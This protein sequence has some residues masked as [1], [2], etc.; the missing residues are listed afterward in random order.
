MDAKLIPA[1]YASKYDNGTEIKRW[2]D[3][4]CTADLESRRVGTPRLRQLR[5]KP[6]KFTQV[7][8]KRIIQ[9]LLYVRKV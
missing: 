7:Q 4:R 6:G 2:W 9:L 3:K 1:M 8:N 5:V